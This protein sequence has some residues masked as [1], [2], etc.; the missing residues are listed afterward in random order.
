MKRLTR[1][2]DDV[3]TAEMPKPLLGADLTRR[4]VLVRL[5]DGCLWAH[6]PVD[7]DADLQSEVDALGSVRHLV[8]P[9]KVHHLGI[10]SWR[11]AYPRATV[12]GAPGLA[13]RVK[14][15]VVDEVLTDHPPLSWGDAFEQEVITA[16]PTINEV[17][18]HHRPSRTLLVTD[19]VF[20]ACDLGNSPGAWLMSLFGLSDR[21][22]SAFAWMM[23]RNRDEM[24]VQI[25]RILGWDFERAL[26]SHGEN[27]PSAAKPQIR[28]AFAWL[29]EGAGS[30]ILQSEPN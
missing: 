21:V 6:S 2:A 28:Q 1:W 20:H 15:V 23:M 19:V 9:N 12:Y 17:V 24:R 4:M 18:F 11:E 25:R 22:T 8:A 27:L 5:S 13:E 30:R 7:L 10:P 29:L 26:L 16:A 3:W 14:R